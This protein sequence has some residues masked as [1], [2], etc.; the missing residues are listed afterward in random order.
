M[1]A[2]AVQDRFILFYVFLLLPPFWKRHVLPPI[3]LTKRVYQYLSITSLTMLLTVCL[4]TAGL[5]ILKTVC[6]IYCTSARH[7]PLLAGN[8]CH[9]IDI[10]Y[11]VLLTVSKAGGNWTHECK[12]Q[13]LVRLPLRHSPIYQKIVILHFY[14]FCY[15]L[16]G[17][18]SKDLHDIL[19]Q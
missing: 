19:L 14:M 6:I 8:R 2:R 11:N 5:W 10:I 16:H 12:G 1:S 13:S 15:V 7:Y 18:W 17:L 3:R 4:T 9:K